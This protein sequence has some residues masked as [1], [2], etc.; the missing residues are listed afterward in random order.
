MNNVVPGAH[1]D[2]CSGD[3][4]QERRSSRERC[5]RR[6]FLKNLR[7]TRRGKREQNAFDRSAR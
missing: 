5:S 2:R 4:S 7:W 6:T 1:A 3:K